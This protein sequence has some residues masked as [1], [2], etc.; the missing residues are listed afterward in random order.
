MYIH[1][2]KNLHT[3]TLYLYLYMPSQI[4][5]RPGNG[6]AIHPLDKDKDTTVKPENTTPGI[7]LGF[8]PRS[9]SKGIKGQGESNGLLLLPHTA[10]MIICKFRI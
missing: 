3:F 2:Y 5:P 7:L 9:S 10:A 1:I 4:R 6:L 8:P